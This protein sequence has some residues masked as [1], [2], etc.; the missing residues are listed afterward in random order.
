MKKYLATILVSLMTISAT[1]AQNISLPSP[2]KKGG[3]SVLEAIEN[4]SSAHGN[5][6]PQGNIS[7]KE[8][9]VLL[10]AASGHNRQG[11]GWVVPTAMN[12]DPYVTIYILGKE[13]VFR[14]QRDNH[15]L[16]KVS[17]KD[18][19]GSISPQAFVGSAP[20]ILIYTTEKSGIELGATLVGAMTQNIYM[21]SQ[22]LNIGVRYMM[23]MKADIV[24]E[25]LK[26]KESEQPLS[27]LPIGHY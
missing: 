20:Y 18:I 17:D 19:R 12:K 16:D 3:P 24:R 4:R 25:E 22:A 14:Y 2:D 13:G 23:T 1:S 21:A 5:S 10:W 27:I 8:L 7:E 26:L 9:S 6:F 15:S 11:K